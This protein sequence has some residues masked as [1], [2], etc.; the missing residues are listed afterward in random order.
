MLVQLRNG[1]LR[2]F[3]ESRKILTLGDNMT[4]KE[5]AALRK[6]CRHKAEIPLLIIATV[7][8]IA[9]L[10]IIVYY[11]TI[12]K[13]TPEVIKSFSIFIGSDE[14]MAE[15]LLGG[16]EF[17]AAIVIVILLGRFIWALYRDNGKARAWETPI[18]DRQFRPV[19]DICCEYAQKLG[20]E[21]KDIPDFFVGDSNSIKI[22][23]MDFYNLRSVRIHPAVLRNALKNDGIEIRYKVAKA[24][25]SVFLGYRSFTCVLLLTITDWIPFFHSMIERTMCYSTDRVLQVLMGEEAAEKAIMNEQISFYLYSDIDYDVYF[26]DITN[27]S[28]FSIF[29]E[30][31]LSGTPIPRYRIAAIKD[32]EKKDG[33]LF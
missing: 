27:F 33:R 25:A 32:P 4:K 13:V 6:Q 11:G 23:K 14:K 30:N 7:I 29:L 31:L 2:A 9:I 12:M 5:L 24:T 19:Y 21:K 20:I 28:G 22:N 10:S 1:D 8:S 17:I 16:R 15:F 26:E 3:D 18:T